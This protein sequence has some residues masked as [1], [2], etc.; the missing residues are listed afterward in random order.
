[1]TDYDLDL[2]IEELILYGMPSVSRDSL[3]I[4]IERE[5]TRLFAEQGLPAAL[6]MP[7]AI[8]Y[9]NGDTFTQPPGADAD[10]L[11]VQI[12]QSI[13]RSIETNANPPTLGSSA[14]TF[15]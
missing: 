13:Y 14:P 5:L 6:R 8:T 9:Q 11:A 15:D 3:G 7:G 1:L 4:A 12:A 10:R 2:A